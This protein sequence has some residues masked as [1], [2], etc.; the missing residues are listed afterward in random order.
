MAYADIIVDISHEML[1]RTYQYAVP[2]AMQEAVF[3]GAPVQIPFGNG[4]KLIGGYIV[5][6]GNEPKIP[7]EKIKDIAKIESGKF[8]IESQ[9]IALAYKIRT[10]YGGTMNDALRTVIPVKKSVKAVEMKTILLQ[11]SREEAE[12]RY[13]EACRKKHRAKSRLLHELLEEEA[14]PYDLVINKLSISRKTIQDFEKENVISIE[15]ERI[16][17][18]HQRQVKKE[19]A[20][21]LNTEQQEIADQIISEYDSGV[22]MSYL[23]HGI[24][25]S[26]KTEVYLALIE[27]IV[28]LNK[29]AIMLIPEIALTYQTMMRFQK[30]FGDRVSFLHSRLS[31]GER[32]D[33]IERASKGEIDVMIGPR[34]ALFTPFPEL[35][36]ILIDE[37]HEP[38]YK[39]EQ[40]P[41][42]HTRELADEYAK[43]IGA[44]VVLGSATPSLEAYCKSEQGLYKR[45]EL[46]TRAKDASL[47]KVHIVDMREELKK[48]NISIFSET[49]HELILDRLEKKQQIMLFINR[50]GYAGFVS[51]RSCGEALLCP[52]CSVSLKAHTGGKLLCHYCGYET[53][54]PKNCPACGSKYIA[55]FGTGTQKVELLVKNA[56]PQA[57][58]LRMDADTTKKKDAHEAILS[59]FSNEE[60]DIL[61]GTQ[62]IVKGHDFG[63]VTLMGILAADLSLQSGDFRSAERTFQLLAQAAGRAGRDKEAGEVVIQTYQP[64]HYCIQAAAKEDYKGFYSSEMLFRRSMRYPPAA[65][66]LAIQLGMKEETAA[67]ERMDT[68]AALAQ[69][70]IYKQKNRGNTVMIGPAPANPAKVRDIYRRMLYFKEEDYTI[71]TDIKDYLEQKIK[72]DSSYN[73]C[74]IQFDFDPMNL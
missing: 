4:N 10:M 37:E 13:D 51:C 74:L 68:L 35:G 29:Q 19:A 52:H 59:A 60:A 43:M 53:V 34:S 39:S 40:T 3:I 21:V 42:Y 64:D 36:M 2:D 25:G 63:K 54:T 45:F 70:F 72:D 73:S 33:Q 17:R 41:K 27:H 69:N 14:L 5:G 48:K 1:D 8:A 38:T 44:S 46:L 16:Y 58:V 28:S 62:M 57:K 20:I 50:R 26:G 71:L 11:C 23:I 24:T 12:K 65:H 9:M 7:V 66:I 31:Q 67:E 32:S 47:P 22:R 56:F 49:L 6:L 15:A 55:A 30:R 18:M 61:V